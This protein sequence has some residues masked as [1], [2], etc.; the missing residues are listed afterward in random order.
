MLV[1]LAVFEIIYT[2]NFACKVKIQGCFRTGKR[3]I[4]DCTDKKGRFW[5]KKNNILKH[6]YTLGIHV[7]PDM[8]FRRLFIASILKL[9]FM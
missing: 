6:D 8:L 5:E 2:Q 3:Q 7:T 9:Y 1:E 4:I